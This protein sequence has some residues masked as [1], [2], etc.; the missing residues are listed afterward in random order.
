[1][2]IVI[3]VKTGKGKAIFGVHFVKHGKHNLKST[4]SLKAWGGGGGGT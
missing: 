1:M 3:F 4:I 2:K